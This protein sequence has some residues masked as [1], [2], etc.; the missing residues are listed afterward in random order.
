M[1]SADAYVSPTPDQ[2]QSIRCSTAVVRRG[3]LAAFPHTVV[4]LPRWPS[5]QL[6]KTCISDARH[7]RPAATWPAVL[8][9]LFVDVVSRRSIRFPL[10][11]EGVKVT[12]C[13]VPTMAAQQPGLARRHAALRVGEF[14]VATGGEIWVAIRAFER[15]T[16]SAF[17]AFGAGL[18]RVHGVHLPELSAH[19]QGLQLAR[20]CTTNQPRAI[21]VSVGRLRLA[22]LHLKIRFALTPCLSATA[23]TEAPGCS[24]TSRI[25]LL[26]AAL[27]LRLVLMTGDSTL[28]WSALWPVKCKRLGMA[29]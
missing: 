5:S 9:W 27:C 29:P 2:D 13:L 17:V 12:S 23:A 20:Y 6:A 22:R 24:T 26:K 1:G 4:S 18:W 21:R 19:H 10:V 11:C 28:A 15:H 8:R 25:L 16:V 14:E 3:R 7:L